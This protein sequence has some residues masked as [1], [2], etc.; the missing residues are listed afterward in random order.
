MKNRN[1]G[2][3]IAEIADNSHDLAH[4]YLSK[5]DI[6]DWKKSFE[7]NGKIFN[8]IAWQLAH[9]AWGENNLILKACGASELIMPWYDTFKI[10]APASTVYPSI[11]E[12]KNTFN[13]VHRL[14]IECIRSMTTEQLDEPNLIDLKF[15]TGNSKRTSIYHHI[16]HESIHIGQLSWLAKMHDIKTI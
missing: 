10:G 11:D 14:S 1:E 3:I 4:F 16:R 13:E 9:M 15:K 2:V 5:L 6:A 12:L 7:L 8:G